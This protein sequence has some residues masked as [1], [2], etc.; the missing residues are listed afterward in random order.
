MTAQAHFAGAVVTSGLT[1]AADPNAKRPSV[2]F[3][4]VDEPAD[5]LR[6]GEPHLSPAPLLIIRELV[7]HSVLRRS[8]IA[9]SA[10]FPDQVKKFPDGPN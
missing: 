7:G 3:G 10:G 5:P 1:W 9:A 2:T 8:E 6:I 4:Q